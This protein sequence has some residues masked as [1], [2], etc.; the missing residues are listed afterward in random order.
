M[1]NIVGGSCI[2]VDAHSEEGVEAQAD[3][4]EGGQDR[5]HKEE[6]E[7]ANREE[8]KEESIKKRSREKNQREQHKRAEKSFTRILA[9]HAG[10][11]CLPIF[12]VCVCAM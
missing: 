6:G 12:A 3:V 10:L 1:R 2:P 7:T 4:D 9:M 11:A 5:L 8:S